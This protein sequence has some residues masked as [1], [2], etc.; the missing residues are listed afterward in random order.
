MAVTLLNGSCFAQV[1]GLE[2]AILERPAVAQ[3]RRQ[4]DAFAAVDGPMLR[5]AA[6]LLIDTAFPPDAVRLQPANYACT[7]TN[8]ASEGAQQLYH[9]CLCADRLRDK[10]YYKAAAEMT[11]TVLCAVCCHRRHLYIA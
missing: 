10:H 2:A 1:G 9:S 6:K 3:R 5:R 8:R 7:M 11:T 4:A